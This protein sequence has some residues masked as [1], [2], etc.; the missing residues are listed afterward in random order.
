MVVVS[1]GLCQG[2]VEVLIRVF[3]IAALIAVSLVAFGGAA[4]ADCRSIDPAVERAGLAAFLK[5]NGYSQKQIAFSL[6]YVDGKAKTWKKVPL[7]Q[8]GEQ[9]GAQRIG[10][11]IYGCVVHSLPSML[12]PR[13]DLNGIISDKEF[14]KKVGV[15][16]IT[17]AEALV[18]GA[19]SSCQGTAMEAF[20]DPKS[21]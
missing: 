18:V 14:L 9:C 8:R 17:V 2:S 11:M 1:R 4:A 16:K 6:R 3:S 20:A 15:S 12:S 13:P 5:Q 7:T 19:A 10:G 21:R